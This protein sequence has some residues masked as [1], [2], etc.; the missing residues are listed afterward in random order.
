MGTVEYT[1]FENPL[2]SRFLGVSS[3]RQFLSLAIKANHHA[4]SR[5]KRTYASMGLKGYGSAVHT[6]GSTYTL[7]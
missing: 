3:T 5:I 6:E 7:D 4:K 1:F 2:V